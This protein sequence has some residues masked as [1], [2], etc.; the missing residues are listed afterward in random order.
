MVCVCDYDVFFIDEKMN[1][2][3]ISRRQM[4]QKAKTKT[5]ILET[6]FLSSNHTDFHA[7]MIFNVKYQEVRLGTET[8]QSYSLAKQIRKAKK[9]NQTL[10]WKT[11]P[12]TL[13]A[14]MDSVA[15]NPSN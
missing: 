9:R 1:V 7:Q 8:A 11:L 15:P 4:G 2:S 5:W 10:D 13:T 12:G 3:L 14:K 6:L